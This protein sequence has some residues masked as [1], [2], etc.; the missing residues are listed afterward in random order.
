MRNEELSD[1]L[2]AFFTLPSLSIAPNGLIG[3]RGG[4]RPCS[5]QLH[6]GGFRFRAW[7]ATRRTVIAEAIQERADAHAGL[8]MYVFGSA[9]LRHAQV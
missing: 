5:G 9:G 3:C 2:P 6:N 8:R 4:V 1:V 7:R